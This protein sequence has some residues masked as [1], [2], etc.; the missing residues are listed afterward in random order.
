M[1]ICK[2]G[3]ANESLLLY[4]KGLVSTSI[5]LSTQYYVERIS[6]FKVI[7]GR[8]NYIWYRERNESGHVVKVVYSVIYLVRHPYNYSR[9]LYR[10]IFV[11]NMSE[12]GV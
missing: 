7:N 12:T 8:S 6:I 5:E 10:K 3:V 4:V 2:K 11:K 9:S 1:Y